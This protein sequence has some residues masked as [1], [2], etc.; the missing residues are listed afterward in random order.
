MRCI[1]DMRLLQARMR[2]KLGRPLLPDLKPEQYLSPLYATSDLSRLE[3][4]G[5][6]EMSFAEFLDRLERDMQN[7]AFSVMRNPSTDDDWHTDMAHFLLAISDQPIWIRVCNI[8]LIPI[9]GGE[10]VSATSM[11]CNPVYFTRV[12]GYALPTDGIFRL[13][14][15]RAERNAIRKRLFAHLGVREASLQDARD[16]IIT[17]DALAYPGLEISRSRLQ[18]LY[19]TA[20]LQG[21]MEFPPRYA[22]WQILDKEFKAQSWFERTWYFPDEGSY[23]PQ[24]LLAKFSPSP[25]ILHPEYMQ[26]CPEKPDKETLSW[27]EWLTTLFS[28]RDMIPL[29]SLTR[30]I[31]S[32]KS[33]RSLSPECLHIAGS[34][35]HEFL[36]FL[37]RSWKADGPNIASNPN[38]VKALL[39]TEVL[40]ESGRMYPLGKTY[41]RTAQIQYADGFLRDGEFFP[42]LK[43]TSSDEAGLPD[44]GVLT[45]ALG[46]GYPKS[47]LEFYITILEFVADA[48]RDK[49]EVVDVSRIFA[50][51][52]RI[53]T[54]YH[55][56][57]TRETSA[58]MIVYDPHMSSTCVAF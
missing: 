44:I 37:L 56:S 32:D 10:W 39:D 7:G 1:K 58:E 34:C 13:I 24:R 52:N 42:W 22:T 31:L 2:D 19:L 57:V 38:L 12:Q 11:R 25:A 51:Y 35:S 48:N 53:E 55:E 43:V 33:F 18:F 8:N 4:Y 5:L 30:S 49:A 3:Q 17:N 29:T 45:T 9:M 27:R 54:R 23:S 15:P 14:L 21:D 40:C 47:D 36:P 41:V 50:L 28:I 26:D 20:H 6:R 16:R 46:F